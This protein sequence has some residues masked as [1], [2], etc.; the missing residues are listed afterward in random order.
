MTKG[1][2]WEMN[3]RVV[4]RDV[5]LSHAQVIMHSAT[6]QMDPAITQGNQRG[7]WCPV[8]LKNALKTPEIS[9]QTHRGLG[10]EEKTP[11][12]LGPLSQQPDTSQTEIHME[13]TPF[14]LRQSPSLHDQVLPSASQSNVGWHLLTLGA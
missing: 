4:R 2:I 13:S 10:D 3:H 9:Q 5:P 7:L 1:N 14:A 8:G 11:T 6:L 12:V